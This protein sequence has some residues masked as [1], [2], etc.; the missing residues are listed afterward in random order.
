MTVRVRFAPSPTG[1]LHIGGARTALY[2]WLFARHYNGTFILRIEDTDETRS[3]SESV[4]GIIKGLH[5]LNLN[6]DEGP[7]IEDINPNLEFDITKIQENGSYGPYFQTIRNENGIY[8]KYIDQLIADGKAYLCYCTPE[9]LDKIRQELMLQKK[10]PKYDMRCRNLTAEQQKQK[11][12]EGRKPVVR[13]KMPLE[14]ETVFT[15]LIREQVKF[16]NQLLDDFVIQKTSGI[17]TYNFACVI[18]DYL[19]KISHVI[20]GDDHLSNT[21]KQIQLYKAL[22]WEYPH[23]AHL[24]MILGSDGARLSKRHGATSVLEYRSLG[25]LPE[26]VINYLAL[27][28][29]GTEDSQQMFS[30]QE[31]V[32]KFSVDRCS[33]SSAIFDN[34]KLIWMNGEYI[35]K[36]PIDDLI[37]KTEEITG[38]I[39]DKKDKK[40]Y[41]Y[42]TSA[43]KLE[44][45]KIKTLTDIPYLIEFFVNDEVKYSPEA[46]KK[47][48]SVPDIKQFLTELTAKIESIAEFTVSEIEKLLREFAKEKKVKTGMVFHS[49]RVCV[50]GR[51]EGPSLFEMVEL[52]GKEKVVFRIKYVIDNLEKLSA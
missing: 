13:F 17:P 19:M 39:V 40:N 44:Q 52:L 9:E 22:G 23:F 34:N 49:V 26:T 16:E 41:N 28:G 12:A 38:K 10:P 30:M 20:R 3:T 43:V 6:W 47:T 50:S 37:S 25:Y 11:V 29:W 36:L 18:D 4:G 24:S 32:E 51:T 35:R 2:N 21:P 5:W 46:V 42:I 8:R 31:L 1:Y 27:L 45:E 7:V 48:L 15:D 14:G 33:K